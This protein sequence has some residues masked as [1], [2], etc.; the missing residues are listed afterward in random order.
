MKPSVPKLFFIIQIFFLTLLV[1]C[2]TLGRP[3]FIS[4]MILNISFWVYI[5]EDH[6]PLTPSVLLLHLLYWHFFHS[7]LKFYILSTYKICFSSAHKYFVILFPFCTKSYL[8]VFLNQIR[9]LLLSSI[10]FHLSLLCSVLHLEDSFLSFL[11]RC[12]GVVVF[13]LQALVLIYF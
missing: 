11:F 7:A 5:R 3:S 6:L 2:D 12:F 1:C 4:V 8:R 10:S 13:F 9:S